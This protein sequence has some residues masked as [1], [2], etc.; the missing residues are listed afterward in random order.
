MLRFKAIS[1]IAMGVSISYGGYYA[2]MSIFLLATG[3][4]S[5]TRTL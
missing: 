4:I 5:G 3:T 1:F 2:L